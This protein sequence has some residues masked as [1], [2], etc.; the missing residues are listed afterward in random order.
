MNKKLQLGLLIIIL[1]FIGGGYGFFINLNKTSKIPKTPE[2][3]KSS[4]PAITYLV[5]PIDSTKYCNGAD[6][7]SAGYRKTITVEQSTSAS[8]VNPTKMQIIRT[9]IDAATDGMCREALDQTEIVENNGIV[10][11]TPFGAWAGVSITMCSCQ[12]Q[13]EVN[14]LRLPGIT[15]VL[16]SAMETSGNAVQKADLIQLETPR[17]NQV[18]SSPLTIKGTA[19][20][21]W[22]FE[23]SF[24]VVLTDWDGKI[25]AQGVAQAKSNWMTTDFVPFEATLKFVVDKASYSNKGSLILKKDNPSGLPEHDDALEIPVIL[26]G[27]TN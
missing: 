24:P 23:A 7:D 6:M 1:L 21:S 8:E 26:A 20:G 3:S 4:S 13:V 11:I 19:R 27:D 10:Y 22:F 15:K 5:S 18:I 2:A 17:P 25:I 14:L 9:V 12:P 16:W